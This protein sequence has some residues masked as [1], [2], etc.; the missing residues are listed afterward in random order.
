MD[1]DTDQTGTVYTKRSSAVADAAVLETE[2]RAGA[3]DDAPTGLPTTTELITV[4][5][6]VSADNTMYDEPTVPPTES[7][8]LLAMLAWGRRQSQGPTAYTKGIG[9]A[10]R[11]V[12][13]A[14]VANTS[15][16]A[17]V[18]VGSPD[19]STGAVRG[20]V[21]VP[22]FDTG[23]VTFTVVRTPTGGS[24]SVDAL[25]NFTYTPSLTARLR[26]GTTASADFDSFSV[27][28][29]DGQQSTLVD[30]E[31]PVLPGSLASGSRTAV[32]AR[33]SHI[34]VSDDGSRL[35]VANRG[36]RTLS[37]IDTATSEVTATI[38]VV[39]APNAVAINA[40]GTFVYVA[41]GYTVS[42]VST[43]DNEVVHTVRV[44]SL[45]SALT[46]SPDGALL[47]VA[48]R[49]SRSISVIDT[50]TN[51]QIDANPSIFSKTIRV[52]SSPSAM[53]LSPDGTRLYVANRGS[54]SISVIDTTTNQQ[55]DAN[56]SIFS[57][58]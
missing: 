54:R 52:G 1:T 18:T 53:A 10:D 9:A 49:G 46:L 47:Y 28:A 44:G 26:A 27:S 15:P 23:A 25:G 4:A 55:I 34:A 5:S 24:V 42:V 7:P 8:L 45:P 41:G 32:G 33:P 13:H 48:N 51:Q 30:I 50:T 37:V 20:I 43:L 19:A 2:A 22:V 12:E 3:P 57:K 17:S 29:K 16:T 40:A 6:A 21:H 11:K 56:P 36:S 31:V 58:T 14:A 39:S 35:Y 38:P